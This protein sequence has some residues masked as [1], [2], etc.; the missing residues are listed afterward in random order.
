LRGAVLRRAH[1]ALHVNVTKVAAP[2][3][4]GTHL[5]FFFLPLS[6]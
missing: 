6:H 2:L 3:T 5:S 4:I 1:G